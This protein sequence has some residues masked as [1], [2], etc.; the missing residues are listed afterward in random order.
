MKLKITNIDTAANTIYYDV[1]QDDGETLVL[2][3]EAASY[4]SEITNLTNPDFSAFAGVIV[5]D[6]TS[7]K[8]TFKTKLE[9]DK[10]TWD[11]LKTQSTNM[12]SQLTSKIADLDTAV[13]AIT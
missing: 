11:D 6:A 4:G 2:A 8:N 5:A 3:G 7:K 13:T 9:A 12:V 10:S 1:Y